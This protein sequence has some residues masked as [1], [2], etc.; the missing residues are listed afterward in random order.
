MDPARKR[1]T[2]E[3]IFQV[4]NTPT[5]V[6]IPNPDSTIVVKRS[7]PTSGISLKF[8]IPAIVI[9]FGIVLA[10]VFVP[11]MFQ[12]TNEVVP[13][14][15]PTLTPATPQPTPDILPRTKNY[16]NIDRG[17]TFEYLSSFTLVECEQS[18]IFLTS[19]PDSPEESCSESHP[20]VLEIWDGDITTPFEGHEDARYEVKE[21][22]DYRFVVALLNPEYTL[23][24]ERIVSTLQ[25]VNPNLN[26]G[27]DKYTSE[28]GYSVQFPPNWILI[29]AE[30]RDSSTVTNI[31][32]WVEESKA[33]NWA[34]KITNVSNAGLSASE[35]MSSLQNLPGWK[36]RPNI[37]FRL[38]GGEV[39][40]ILQGEY[41]N[42][43]QSNIVVWKGSSLV[44]MTWYDLAT[45]PERL[46]F[47]AMLSSFEFID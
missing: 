29:P 4:E 38:I 42:G 37:E 10:A 3:E 21:G 45:Q 14:P 46:T 6:P 7:S 18:I 24:F 25:A 27:W 35:I 16:Y 26:E 40:Q 20:G 13:T 33:N 47:E 36:T 12:Q 5:P 28:L 22:E 17:M 44:E 23:L 30:E 1:F 34:I 19:K 11:R 41:E 9:I 39:A 31:R 8:I 15:E 43:W 32:K 2:T